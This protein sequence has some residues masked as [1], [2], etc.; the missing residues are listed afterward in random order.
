MIN[1]RDKKIGIIV[2]TRPN[3]VKISSLYHEL[4]NNGYNVFLIHTGQ[5]YDYNLSDSFIE[6]FKLKIDWFCGIKDSGNIFDNSIIIRDKIK[7]E[8]IEVVISVGDCRSS[9]IAAIAAKM[10]HTYLIHLESGLR[11]GNLEVIEEINRKLI[12]SM[13]DLLLTTELIANNNIEKEFNNKEVK[14][15]GNTHIDALYDFDFDIKKNNDV[16]VTIHRRENIYNKQLLN[17]LRLIIEEIKN[18]NIKIYAHPH[19]VKQLKAFGLYDFFSEYIREPVDYLSFMKLLS[20]C[21]FVI[22][23]SGGVP[24]EASMFS[25]PCILFR[26]ECEHRIIFDCNKIV[27]SNDINAILANLD[28]LTQSP[29]A[30]W[31]VALSHTLW[32]DGKAG[33]RAIQYFEEYT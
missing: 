31:N 8:N 5:H 25:K 28:Y 17:T 9:L 12:D 7:K 24:T 32:G 19:L 14:L 6:F 29:Y 21:N 27:L 23:D 2:G 33:Y 13:S 11:C 15:I 20:E 4:I 26:K 30:E 18:Y 10:A 3:F 22:T 16:I 1:I